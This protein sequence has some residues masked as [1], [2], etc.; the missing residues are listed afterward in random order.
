V[1]DP[2][3]LPPETVPPATIAGETHKETDIDPWAKEVLAYVFSQPQASVLD[4]KIT[5]QRALNLPEPPKMK[6]H[7]AYKAMLQ[8][9]PILESLHDGTLLH[10]SDALTHFYTQYFIEGERW[11]DYKDVMNEWGI[12]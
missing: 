4:W 6:G 8:A 1:S 7:K 5:V 2:T 9:Y 12:A 10:P 3:T 11:G